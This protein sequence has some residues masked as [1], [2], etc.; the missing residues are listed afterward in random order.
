MVIEMV[1][2]EIDQ[3]RGEFMKQKAKLEGT[4]YQDPYHMLVNSYRSLID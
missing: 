3:G 4:S 1:M 2:N